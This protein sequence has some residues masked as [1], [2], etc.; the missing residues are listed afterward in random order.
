MKLLLLLVLYLKMQS[1]ST[2]RP[3]SPHLKVETAQPMVDTHG[4]RDPLGGSK[5]I[6]LRSL[7]VKKREV[8]IDIEKFISTVSLRTL[9]SDINDA[10]NTYQNLMMRLSFLKNKLPDIKSTSGAEGFNSD[11]HTMGE[12]LT[13][14]Y[15]QWCSTAA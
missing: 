15:M 1:P 14:A 2:R 5:T 13:S 12:S 11:L 6:D 8:Q 3:H 4:N 9:E 10:R 7:R